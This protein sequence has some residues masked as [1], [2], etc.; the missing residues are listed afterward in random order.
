M[1]R[2]DPARARLRQEGTAATGF[3]AGED[4]SFKTGINAAVDGGVSASNGQLPQE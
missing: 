1:R 4:A 2:T 3:L